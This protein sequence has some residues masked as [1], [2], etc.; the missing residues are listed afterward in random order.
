MAC[1]LCERELID[2]K[3][4]Q[5]GYTGHA[6]HGWVSWECLNT[7]GRFVIEYTGPAAAKAMKEYNALRSKGPDQFKR[8]FGV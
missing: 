5:I 7:G 8:I 6:D 2:G 4:I 1:P 3:H